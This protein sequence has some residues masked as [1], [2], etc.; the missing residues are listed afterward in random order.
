MVRAKIK[1]L[2]EA[3]PPPRGS[4]SGPRA[5][6]SGREKVIEGQPPYD[7]NTVLFAKDKLVTIQVP[8]KMI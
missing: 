1:G 5:N 8:K 2:G 6:V 7:V 4:W 3:P